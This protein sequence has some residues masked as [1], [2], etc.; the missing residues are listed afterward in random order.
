MYSAAR[1]GQGQGP[2]LID[3]A[4]TQLPPP[5]AAHVLSGKYVEAKDPSSL[6]AAMARN[7]DK[8][9]SEVGLIDLKKS[10]AEAH[11]KGDRELA[12]QLAQL[13]E[14]E[15]KGDRELVARIKTSLESSEHILD[16]KQVD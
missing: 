4:P 11:R 3:L 8:R 14:A 15:R 6:L 2:T 1:A 12:R 5:S 10:L 7:L 13:A 16:G 9:K